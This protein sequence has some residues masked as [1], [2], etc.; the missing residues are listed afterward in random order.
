MD[1][2]SALDTIYLLNELTI[3][4]KSMARFLVIQ[5]HTIITVELLRILVSRIRRN[6]NA[7]KGT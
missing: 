7:D 2:K 4:T 3:Y 1:C 5:A 6:K